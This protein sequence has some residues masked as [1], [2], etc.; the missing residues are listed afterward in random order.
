MWRNGLRHGSRLLINFFEHKMLKTSLFNLFSIPL[1][2]MNF[3]FDLAAI[4]KIDF[5]IGARCTQN[6]VVFQIDDFF[7][8]LNNRLNITGDNHLVLPNPKE[9]RRTIS[10]CH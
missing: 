9:K 4:R 6:F 7:C 8:V 3:F 2:F 1:D 5:K 10:K